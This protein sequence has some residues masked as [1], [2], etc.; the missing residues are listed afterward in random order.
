MAT[1]GHPKNE[2]RDVTASDRLQVIDAL[3]DSFP[4]LPDEAKW[5]LAILAD[6]IAGVMSDD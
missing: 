4:L 2:R 6:E 1:P 5:L 3:V